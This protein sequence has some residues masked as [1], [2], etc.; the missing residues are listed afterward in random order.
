MLEDFA[1]VRAPQAVS[2]FFPGA[3][4]HLP[5]IQPSAGIP[6]LFMCG[7]FIDRGGH[8]SWSQEKALVEG[9]RAAAAVCKH[10]GVR[11]GY[12]PNILP[13]EEDEP[14]VALGRSAFKGLRSALPKGVKV[15]VFLA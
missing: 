12:Y 8:R 13:V 15:G 9:R 2:H 1:V 11:E 10:L 4:Q 7:D 3:F 5:R 6:S 14:H